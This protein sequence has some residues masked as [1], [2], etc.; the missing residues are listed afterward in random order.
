MGG[1]WWIWAGDGG[2]GR[3]RSSCPAKR[4]TSPLRYISGMNVDSCQHVWEQCILH[5]IACRRRTIAIQQHR[6]S[7]CYDGRGNRLP[8]AI[9]VRPAKQQLLSETCSLIPIK[10]CHDGEARPCLASECAS[11]RMS[12]IERGLLQYAPLERFGLNPHCHHGIPR[13]TLQLR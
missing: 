6:Q 8:D 9:A 4:G 10:A 1:R 11:A 3:A 12:V 5:T 2:Y 13:S 7:A